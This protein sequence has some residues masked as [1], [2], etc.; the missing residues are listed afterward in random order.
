MLQIFTAGEVKMK[1]AKKGEPFEM[2]DGNVSGVF[3]EVVPFTKIVQKW[4]LK[5]WP[6]GHFSDVVIEIRQSS[7][8]TRVKVKQTN[9]PER[10]IDNTKMGWRKYYF[11]AMKR[12]FGF[13][14]ALI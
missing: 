10:E 11:E 12:C 2:I 9:V 7:D 6:A 13:G 14:A 8:D 5:S 4:R 1:E 3:V